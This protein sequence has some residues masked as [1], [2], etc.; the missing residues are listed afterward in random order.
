MGASQSAQCLPGTSALQGGGG[1]QEY[2]PSFLTCSLAVSVSLKWALTSCSKKLAIAPGLQITSSA[3]PGKFLPRVPAEFLGPSLHQSL[4]TGSCQPSRNWCRISS[5][6]TVGSVGMREGQLPKAKSG[7]LTKKGI[8][9]CRDH[10]SQVHSRSRDSKWRFGSFL[11]FLEIS[12]GS[13][14]FDDL[15]QVPLISLSLKDH[16][17]Y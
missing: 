12:R 17:Y 6:Q 15:P 13:H 10:N 11:R 16:F 1:S 2:F 9:C 8:R 7:G 5:T 14:C 4:A 3:S